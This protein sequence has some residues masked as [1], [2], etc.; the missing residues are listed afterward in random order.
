MKTILHCSTM[1]VT[2]V[3]A[4]GMAHYFVI[5]KTAGELVKTVV[6]KLAPW[7]NVVVYS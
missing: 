1:T 5:G 3:I 4:A 6:H 7:L 2:M